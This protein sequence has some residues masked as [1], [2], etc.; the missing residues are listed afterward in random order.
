MTLDPLVSVLTPSYNQAR[1]LGDNLRSV[2]T[3]SYPNIE[4]I[5]MD[6]GSTDGSIDLL[7]QALPPEHWRSKPDD[8]QSDALNRAFELSTGDIIGWLNS[9]DAYFSPES[10]ALAVEAFHQHPAADVVYGHAALVNAAGEVLHVMWVPPGAARLL[11]FH[12]FLVQ[13][14]VFVRRRVVQDAFVDPSFDS[15]MDWELWLRLARRAR[16]V[17]LN[18]VLAIDRHQP[19]RKVVAQPAVAAE[20][21][22]RL[23]ASY[24]L[25]AGPWVAPVRKILKMSMRLTGIG[26]IGELVTTPLAF[27]GRVGAWPSVLVRQ[28]AVPRSRMPFGD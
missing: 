26:R 16:F 9:D 28:L 7:R 4:H 25:S 22:R 24:S 27:Q 14:A 13:P 8:G 12:N 3:Q 17:R 5:V 20:E 6:G 23:E 11:R 15:M 21:R 1:W 2:G 19:F 18:R 10:V